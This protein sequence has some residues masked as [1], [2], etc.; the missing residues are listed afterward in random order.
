MIALTL[1]DRIRNSAGFRAVYGSGRRFDGQLMTVFILP[2]GLKEHRFGITASR[3]MAR[4]AVERNR[5]KRLLREAFRLSGAELDALS[6]K[7][8]WVFNARRSLLGV[9]V[10]AVS[11]ELRK[12]IARLRADDPDPLSTT[13]T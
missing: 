3:R 13:N 1:R 9:K 10:N 6:V 12:V 5:A 7:Y 2:N 11:E 4:S 8:D